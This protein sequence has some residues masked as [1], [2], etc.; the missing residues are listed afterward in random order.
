MSLFKKNICLLILIFIISSCG[1]KPIYKSNLD[2]SLLENK[3][4]IENID[5]DVGFY[6]TQKLRYALNDFGGKKKVNLITEIKITERKYSFSTSNQETRV[7]ITGL[8][9]CKIVD[10]NNKYSFYL[11]EKVSYDISQSILANKAAETNAKERLANLLSKAV[12][13]N[14]YHSNLNWVK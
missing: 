4:S 3:I 2:N 14:I 8:I 12:L 6:L 10:I 13:T 1:L 5:S 7:E 11:T 9:N